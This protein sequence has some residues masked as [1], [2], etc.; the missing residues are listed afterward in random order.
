MVPRMPCG[1]WGPACMVGASRRHASR[2][3]TARSKNLLYA[4]YESL[5]RTVRARDPRTSDAKIDASEPL[6]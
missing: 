1:M 3:H 6:I 4:S 5:Y 2:D